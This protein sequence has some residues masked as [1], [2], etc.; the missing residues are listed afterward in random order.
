M[1]SYALP[2]NSTYIPSNIIGIPL[3]LVEIPLNSIAHPSIS[4]D[5]PLTAIDR[6][7][8]A[9]HVHLSSY[10]SPFFL[11][12]LFV[13]HAIINLHSKTIAFEGS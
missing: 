10:A 7:S 8:D 11:L 13:L 5:I 12:I 1:N 4:I 6:P 3:H 9:S 2:L